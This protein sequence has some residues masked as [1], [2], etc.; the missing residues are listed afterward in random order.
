MMIW[1]REKL[2]RLRLWRCRKWISEYEAEEAR[3]CKR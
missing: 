2:L 3:Q 1:L